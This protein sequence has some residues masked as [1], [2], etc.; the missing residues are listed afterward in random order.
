M[1]NCVE[2]WLVKGVWP[3]GGRLSTETQQS[4]PLCAAFLPPG[5]GQ[6]H[7]LTWGLKS[8]SK[9]GMSEHYALFLH[10]Q[11]RED[12]NGIFK[13]CDLLLGN[14]FSFLSSALQKRISYFCVLHYD[15]GGRTEEDKKGSERKFAF[16]A[17]SEASALRYCL[18]VSR[19]GR[20]MIQM[21]IG[22]NRMFQGI[23]QISAWGFKGIYFPLRNAS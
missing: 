6:D 20:E 14:G 3:N 9:Q 15:E 21:V 7:S 23:L 13:L 16:K 18:W 19:V 22:I 8:A 17:I 4:R 11:T 12:L 1:D 5:Y 10:R 2:I